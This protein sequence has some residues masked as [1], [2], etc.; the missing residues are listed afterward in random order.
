MVAELIKKKTKYFVLIK[1]IIQFR[2]NNK[3]I[4][5][6]KNTKK[7]RFFIVSAKGSNGPERPYTAYTQV[8]A[9]VEKYFQ[10]N[11]VDIKWT[12]RFIRA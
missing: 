9:T 1:T 4:T 7:N 11:V 6:N 2:Q 8:L 12:N 10:F 5:T 3:N